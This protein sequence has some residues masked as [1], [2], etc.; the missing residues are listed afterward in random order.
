MRRIDAPLAVLITGFTFSLAANLLWTWPGGPVR[1]LGGALASL[2]LPGAIHL[3]P[4]IPVS[5]WPTR[6]LRTVVMSTIAA[7]AAFTTFSHASRLLVQHG[8]DPVLACL[9]PVTTELLV[10]MGVLARR[11][12]RPTTKAQR[13][14]SKQ[15]AQRDDSASAV[16]PAPKPKSDSAPKSSPE[17]PTT[18]VERLDVRASRRAR[19]IA[20]ARANWPVTSSQIAEAVGCHRSEGGRIR[21]IVE[22]E[23]E[24]AS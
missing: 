13:S 12:E 15:R 5:G 3:W 16:A 23:M 6:I 1:I 9:Y 11:Q 20:W 14:P 2:A 17:R 21:K 18:D 4:R 7:M 24:K 8:E 19:G 10:V 22:S